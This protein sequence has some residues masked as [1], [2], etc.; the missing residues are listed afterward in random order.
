MSSFLERNP[1]FAMQVAETV[2]EQQ[3]PGFYDENGVR[4]CSMHPDSMAYFIEQMGYT[5]I[6]RPDDLSNLS[7]SMLVR[8]AGALTRS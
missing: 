8:Y 2:L 6:V 5:R 7:D 1:D 4:V 3:G